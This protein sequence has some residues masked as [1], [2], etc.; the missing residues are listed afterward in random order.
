MTALDQPA[1]LPASTPIAASFG[2]RAAA[3]LLDTVAHLALTLGIQFGA[4]L[5][6]GAVAAQS[7]RVLIQQ[8]AV[9]GQCLALAIA[10]LVQLAYFTLFEWLYGATPGKLALGLRVVGTDGR[11]C[12]L[13]QAVGRGVARY[14]P[15][16]LFFGLVANFSMRANDNQRYGDRASSTLVLRAGDPF[17][18]ERRS[19]LRFLAAAVLVLLV[20]ALHTWYV[21]RTTLAIV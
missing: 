21:A 1:F 10:L 13:R 16:G 19:G 20:Y 17:I 9:G 8:P 14:F 12:G 15:D 6:L 3:Y 4:G 18:L 11:P 2:V 7:G 5:M